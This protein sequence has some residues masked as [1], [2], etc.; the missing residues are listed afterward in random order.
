MSGQKSEE[1]QDLQSQSI[2]LKHLSTANQKVV[3]FM[4]RNSTGTNNQATK[5]NTTSQ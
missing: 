3:T 4:C 5:V 1:M 2:S